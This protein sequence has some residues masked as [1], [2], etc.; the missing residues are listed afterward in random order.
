MNYLLKDWLWQILYYTEYKMRTQELIFASFPNLFYILPD[1]YVN[2]A[3]NRWGYYGR[4]TTEWTAKAI[5]VTSL[6]SST[7]T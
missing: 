5:D 4:M 1:G 3:C 2:A 6:V 7:D